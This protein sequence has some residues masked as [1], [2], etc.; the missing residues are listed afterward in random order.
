MH[1]FST[2][3]RYTV[4]LWVN[5]SGG[6][7]LVAS[8]ALTVDPAFGTP[9]ISA[10]PTPPTLGQLV[11]FIASESGGTTPCGYAW[12]FGDGT[13]G[14][15]LQKISHIFTTNGPFTVNVTITDS[16]GAS[17]VQSLNL[18]VVAAGPSP[19]AAPGVNFTSAPL[20]AIYS[21]AGVLLSLIVTVVVQRR[22][23]RARLQ[24]D[25]AQR[26]PDSESRPPK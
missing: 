23:W 20:L 11:N 22:R 1:V 14:G 4:L 16:S 13:T 15:N 2:A 24:Q 19:N 12:Q 21:L 10:K 3:G 25:V 5:D 7:H 6:A 18:T 17:G 9:A 8:F 26:D